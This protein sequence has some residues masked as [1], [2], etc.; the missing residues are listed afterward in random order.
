VDTDHNSQ[1]HRRTDGLVVGQ[2]GARFGGMA[3]RRRR[4][5]V[6]PPEKAVTL[7][8]TITAKTSRSSV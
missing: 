3:G 2:T 1:G 6:E 5:T 7:R 4:A 8:P